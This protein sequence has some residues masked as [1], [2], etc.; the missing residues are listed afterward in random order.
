MW[1]S[2]NMTP[3]ESHCPL[4]N[5]RLVI[6]QLKWRWLNCFGHNLHLA[7]I[8]GGASENARTGQAISLCRNVVGQKSWQKKDLIK[9]QTELKLPKHSLILVK[10][11]KLPNQM[12][13]L[14]DDNTTYGALSCTQRN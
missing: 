3:Y 12:K 7:V 5:K 1:S 2:I 14:H 4:L 9:A 10:K 6:R 11:K 8:N 13:K